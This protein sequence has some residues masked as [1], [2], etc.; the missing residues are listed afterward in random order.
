M[1]DQ[2]FMGIDTDE[3]KNEFETKKFVNNIIETKSKIKTE[4]DQSKFNNYK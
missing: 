1:I 4:R 2:Q 3:I